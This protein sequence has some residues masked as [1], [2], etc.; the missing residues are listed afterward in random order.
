MEIQLK[1]GNP[2]PAFF[3]ALQ[4]GVEVPVP[5]P[6]SLESLLTK[7]WGLDREFAATKIGTVFLNGTPVDDLASVWVGEGDVVA[8]SGPMPGLAG[9]ILRRGSPLAGLRRGGRPE[10]RGMPS[11][12]PNGPIHIHVKLFNSLIGD[13]GPRLIQKGVI[14]DG[15][16]A[17]SVVSA[18]GQAKPW[19]SHGVLVNGQAMDLDRLLR[20]LREGAPRRVRFVWSP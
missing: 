11:G 8:L 4:Q 9:A 1:E 7:E 13:M 5:G 2:L 15:Q 19:S 18:L 10:S 20:A 16:A 3:P 14:L 12:E 6:R 17:L